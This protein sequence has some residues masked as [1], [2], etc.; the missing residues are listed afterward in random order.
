MLA[1]RV[2]RKRKYRY[3]SRKEN[4][5]HRLIGLWHMIGEQGNEG[6]GGKNGIQEGYTEPCWMMG[7]AQRWGQIEDAWGPPGGCHQVEEVSTG[8]VFRGSQMYGGVVVGEAA[9]AG[10]KNASH[11]R[12]EISPLSRIDSRK[13]QDEDTWCSA[14]G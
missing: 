11:Q 3:K 5:G 6:E 14:K 12:I 10:I 9:L 4:N 2:K 8:V 1:F 7:G 13:S